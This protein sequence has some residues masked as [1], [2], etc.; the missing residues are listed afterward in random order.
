VIFG[1]N[2]TIFEGFARTTRYLT[3][4]NS[5]VP[6]HE[7]YVFDPGKKEFDPFLFYN[8]VELNVKIL[9]YIQDKI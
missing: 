2:C 6:L 8:T 3:F 7:I 1:K 5:S 9:P 4:E